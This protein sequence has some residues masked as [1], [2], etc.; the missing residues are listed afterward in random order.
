[1]CKL[2][3]RSDPLLVP[4]KIKKGVVSPIIKLEDIVSVTTFVPTRFNTNKKRYRTNKRVPVTK[5]RRSERILLK[6]EKMK[7]DFNSRTTHDKNT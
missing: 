5:R 6:L 1:M 7:V 3:I 4:I 2:L